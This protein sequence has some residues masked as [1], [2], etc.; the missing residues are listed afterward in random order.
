M[1]DATTR[2]RLAH[3][4]RSEAQRRTL[5]REAVRI[6][7]DGGLVVF[8]TD[9]VYGIAAHA[10]RPDALERIYAVKRRPPSRQIA[11]L[12][13]DPA[14]MRELADEVPPKAMLLGQRYWPGALTL[15]LRGREA[16]QTLAVRQPD[17][18]IPRALIR[19]LGR[20]L[21]TTSANLSGQASPRTAQD[22][23]AQLPTGYELLIDGGSCPGGTDSTVVDCTGATPRVLRLGALDRGE[24]EA[25]VGPLEGP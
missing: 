25:L 2:P 3:W 7:A 23:L 1:I 14:V 20:P 17:H 11:L 18:P 8:P 9:T 16:G 22:V 5:M 6:L 19:A 10:T 4:P 13:D 24:L 21:A 12:I 15:V